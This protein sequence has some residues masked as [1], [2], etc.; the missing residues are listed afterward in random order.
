M[1]V[2]LRE[3]RG[4]VA[5][6]T[7]N[8]PE[9]SNAINYECTVE[10]GCAYDELEADDT[11]KAVVLTGAGDRAFSAGAD[12]KGFAP[13]EVAA[14]GDLG[15]RVSA[16]GGFGG[17]TE[18]FFPKPLIAA[19]NGAARGGGLEMILACDIVVAEDHATFGLPE[20]KIGGL[21]AAGGVVRLPRRVP[22]NIGLEMC[23]LGEPIDAAR[24]YAVG[25]VNRV[26]P[27]GASVEAAVAIGM[28]LA[29]LPFH[30]VL[31]AKRIAVAS[32]RLHEDQLW[33]MMTSG[34]AD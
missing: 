2:V 11:V 12:L 17:I 29:E 8:R 31:N 19:V 32:V 18:R 22:P 33:P 13:P 21:A 4:P 34:R 16:V 23:M 30:A 3:Q 28:Q 20:V 14:G 25:L 6:L 9:A 24:G 15:E 26:V 10:L 27:T 1:G 5:V 7:M